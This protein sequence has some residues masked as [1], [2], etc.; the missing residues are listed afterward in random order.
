M[1]LPHTC[2]RPTRCVWT[3]CRV[4]PPKQRLV[5]VWG[6]RVPD[7]QDGGL[8]QPVQSGHRHPHLESPATPAQQQGIPEWQVG[9]ESILDC[10]VQLGLVCDV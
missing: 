8:V 9:L 10:I 7:G 2:V 4:P 3:Q 1:K 6:L 5:H